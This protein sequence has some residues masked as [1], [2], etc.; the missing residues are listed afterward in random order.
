MLD[1]LLI[2]NF[3]LIEDASLQF[4]PGLT[5][6][7]GE[8][9]AGKTLLTQALGLLLGERATEDMLG[10]RGDESLIQAVFNLSEDQRAASP[11]SLRELLGETDSELVAGRR[12]G[13]GGR[14]RCFLNGMVVPREVLRDALGGLLAFTAQQEHR[15]LLDSSYQLMAPR[16]SLLPHNNARH[17]WSCRR[18]T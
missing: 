7:T 12:L 3:V 14:G 2:T 16:S 1:S 9:G 18:L 17:G 4:A 10:P 11:Q 13:A 5:V 8:T 15:R 6:L